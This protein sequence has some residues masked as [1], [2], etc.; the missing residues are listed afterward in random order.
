MQ[1]II[2]ITLYRRHIL[3]ISLTIVDNLGLLIEEVY[4]RFRI[5]KFTPFPT[6]KESFL[7]CSL[8]K[9]TILMDNE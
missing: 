7:R 9:E 4:I 2:F 3:S 1:S 6:L 8:L 5:C